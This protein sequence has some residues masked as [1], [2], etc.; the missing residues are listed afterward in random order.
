MESTIE[1]NAIDQILF[2]RI[3][4]FIFENHGGNLWWHDRYWYI[5]A[6]EFDGLTLINTK[7]TRHSLTTTEPFAPS[8]CAAIVSNYKLRYEKKQ[9]SWQAGV[10]G[11]IN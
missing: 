8:L 4:D 3:M 5:V 1:V 9:Y 6:P 10:I 7:V 2:D 11:P